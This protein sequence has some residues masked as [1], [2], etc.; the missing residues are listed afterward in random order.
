MKIAKFIMAAVV[1]ASATMATA[2][3][4]C[5]HKENGSLWASTNPPIKGKSQSAPAVPVQTSGVAAVQ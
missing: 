3:P 1:L 2:E 4:K 5:A